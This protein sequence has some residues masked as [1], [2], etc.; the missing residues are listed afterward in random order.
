MNQ[1]VAGSRVKLKN[2]VYFGLVP[3]GILFDAGDSS[4]VLKD[5]SAYPL[6][7]KLIALIDA[8]NPVESILER[9]PAKLAEFFRRLLAS[10]SEHG[11]LLAVE[12][13]E[14]SADRLVAHTAS[15]E[16]RKFLEDRLQGQG[17]EAALRRWRDAQVVVIGGGPALLSAVRALADSGCGHLSVQFDGAATPGWD[18]LRDE[19]E[20]AQGPRLALRAAIDDGSP[21][22][23]AG[24]L[25]YIG[26]GAITARAAQV[27]RTMRERGIAGAIGAIVDGRA[28]VAPASQAGRPGIADLLHWLPP[29]DPNSATL[30]SVA[31][32]LLGCVVAQA[33]ICRYFGIE[34]AASG[35]QAAIVSADLEVEYRML[36]A[37]ARGE[38]APVPFVHPSKYQ[39]PEGRALL[40]FER[41]KF[42]L[43]P[44]LD[45]LLGPFSVV[46]DDRIEQVPLMQY[47]VRVRSASEAGRERIVVGWGLEHAAAVVHGLSQAVAALAHSFQPDLPAPVC[48][49]EEDAW[50]RLA[51][52]QAV[53][54]SEEMARTQQWA[55]VDL[56]QLPPGPARVLHALLRFHAPDGIGLRLQWNSAGDAFIARV[57]HEHTA[58][59]SAVADSPLGA[60]ELAL[61]KACSLFQLQG[62]HGD[63]FDPPLAL[64]EP[65][66][67]TQVPDWR[68][69]L[70]AA[71]AAAPR[72]ADFHLFAAPGLPPGVYCGHASLTAAAGAA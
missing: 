39:M 25:L 11:M 65:A 23:S 37:S 17:V 4:F 58:L 7:E 3:D 57:S 19:I 70:I 36:V 31:K 12:A 43:E 42:A 34:A 44:W 27:E 41:V 33:A 46:A 71:Q 13:E 56:A 29:P 69:A 67:A 68:T 16:L 52:A 8:G 1:T 24:M 32:A 10:L 18:E 47:P 51:L 72:Q 26:D 63:R 14:P 62:L 60:V 35:G 6:V 50:K 64:P 61:G 2:H 30:G 54:V 59:C 49:F 22:E 48:A 20:S 53:A 45:P 66:A 40:P 28:W 21:I 15:N 38:G 55:W 9:A 5:A